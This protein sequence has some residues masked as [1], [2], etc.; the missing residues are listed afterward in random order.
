MF[1]GGMCAV[2]ASQ[3]PEF[4]QQ[5][6]QRLGGAVNELK[7][8]VGHFDR[9]AAAV[10][11]GR[12]A[13]LDRLEASDDR[14]VNYRGKSMRT[15][16]ERFEKLSKHQSEMQAQDLLS[17]VSSMLVHR[18]RPIAM[19][20]AKDFRPAI[21]LTAEGLFSGLMGFLAGAFGG[22]LIASLMKFIFMR[23]GRHKNADPHAAVKI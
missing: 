17:R 23:K 1:L 20:A 5:Y 12:S 13:G 11:L 6:A 2:G 3:A 10:G 14:F 15:T 4:A 21:P 7:V 18:D 22:G 9:D 16:V 8:V 19:M